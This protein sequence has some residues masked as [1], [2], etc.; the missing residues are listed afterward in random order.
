MFESLLDDTTSAS[1]LQTSGD[2]C[3]YKK[4]KKVIPSFL[5]FYVAA[6][7][8]KQGLYHIVMSNYRVF[9]W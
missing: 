2:F 4:L 9:M 8:K 1:S 6:A 3:I 5:F 7:K